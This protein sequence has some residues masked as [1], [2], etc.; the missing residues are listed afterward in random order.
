M[1]LEAL[2]AAGCCLSLKIVAQFLHE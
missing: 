2:T 1:G